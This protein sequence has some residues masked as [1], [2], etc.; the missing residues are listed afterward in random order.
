[1]SACTTQS[2]VKR[3]ATEHYMPT[4]RVDLHHHC[5]VDPVDHLTYTAIDLI[6][7]ARAH[8]LHVL[9][10]TPHGVVFES[11]TAQ[12][13]AKDQ[14]VLLIPGVEKM[15]EGREVVLLNVSA[16]DIPKKMTFKGLAALR[17]KRGE[18]V[19]VMAP[20]P[21]YPRANCVGPLLD[22]HKVLF[23]AVEHSHLYSFFWNPNLK[24][25]EWAGQN[26]KA[27]L[28]NSDTHD[29]AMLGR[30]WTEVEAEELS[31]PAVFAA[32]RAGQTRHVA[33]PPT[34]VELGLFVAKVTAYQG[35]R[36][37][38]GDRQEKE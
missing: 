12:A 1:M 26:G 23:D 7:A 29:L 25:V 27:V 13:Y 6:D 33:R 20:H 19:L 35:I 4:F 10:I 2:Q 32:I 37:L 15:V 34:L 38:L 17:E 9:A 22:E 18:E 28:A 14:G 24:A 3:T 11:P 36:R 5:D 30:N 21:F 16:G 8:G 31:I